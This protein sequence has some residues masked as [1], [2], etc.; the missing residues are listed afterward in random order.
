MAVD[1]SVIE[2]WQGMRTHILS[3]NVTFES[4]DG[5]VTAHD[6]V[7]AVTSP[8]LKAMLES[9]MTEGVSKRIKVQDSSA[10]G[11]SLFLDILYM[12]STCSDPDYIAVLVALDLAHRWQV[13][14]IVRIFEDTLK[15]MITDVSFPAIAEAAVLKHLRSLEMACMS[16]AK[17]NGQLIQSFSAT[18]HAISGSSAICCV[19]R[20]YFFIITISRLLHPS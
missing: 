6:S 1:Q 8:V 15:D 12:S 11:V 7:L 10:A 17:S 9:S 4:A 19:Y 13:P 16:F 5:P 18:C 2:R 20:Q 14:S 3:H